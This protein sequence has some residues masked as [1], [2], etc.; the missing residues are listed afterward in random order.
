V[1]KAEDITS[2]LL[3]QADMPQPKRLLKGY[4]DDIENIFSYYFNR[5]EIKKIRGAKVLIAG[6]GGLGSNL[7]NILIRTGFINLVLI[8]YDTVELKNLNRQFFFKSDAGKKKVSALKKNLLK[9][10]PAARIKAINKKLDEKSFEKIIKEE[11]PDIIVEAV[12]LDETKKFIFE[13][14]LRMK[15]FVVMASG[16][17]G[18]GDCENIKIIRRDNYTIVGDLIKSVNDFKP[19]APKVSVVAA[20]EADEVLRRVLYDKKR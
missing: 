5:D 6:C 2:T 15:R 16:I 7:S 10:N 13:T 8:D 18:Y 14:S 12:D 20:M 17:A 19:L 3:S 11:N 1:E 4:M 9:I